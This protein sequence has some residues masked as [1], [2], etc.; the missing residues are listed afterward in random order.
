MNELLARTKKYS[1]KTNDYVLEDSEI[2]VSCNNLNEGERS[3]IINS[4]IN[5]E[6]KNNTLGYYTNNNRGRNYL[7]SMRSN[8]NF[9][10]LFALSPLFDPIGQLYNVW[11]D[12]K[13]TT[14]SKADFA[15]KEQNGKLI[16]LL[17]YYCGQNN[18]STM[19]YEEIEKLDVDE[20]SIVNE[21]QVIEQLFDGIK[22]FQGFI[23]FI[24]EWN[25]KD[26]ILLS[27]NS[28]K[29]TK[30]NKSEAIDQL[31][32]APLG[33][34]MVP[35]CADFIGWFMKSSESQEKL[36]KELGLAD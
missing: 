33:K 1:E 12:G 6:I 23:D 31:F 16:R 28:L 30:S 22:S 25:N 5:Y 19:S 14:K 27:L 9:F 17:I 15:K 29:D 4:E 26:D 21:E 32:D 8:P 10:T 34:G 36:E 35:K 20:L 2:S 18:I 3:I 13:Q 11:R 24:N 7:S